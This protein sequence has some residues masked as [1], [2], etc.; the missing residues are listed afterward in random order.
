MILFDSLEN[1]VL[2]DGTVSDWHGILQGFDFTVLEANNIN[3]VLY[4]SEQENLQIK[5]LGVTA[6]YNFADHTDIWTKATSPNDPDLANAHAFA[7]DI[8]KMKNGEPFVLDPSSAL[9]AIVYMKAPD[10]L[11]SEATDPT[12][13]NNRSAEERKTR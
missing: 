10:T 3:P 8:R 2:V 13:Y 11:E 1:Y 7:I 6:D 4:Y 12:A 9:T 5:N